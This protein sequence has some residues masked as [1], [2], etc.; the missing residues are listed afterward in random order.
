MDLLEQLRLALLGPGQSDPALQGFLRDP[1]SRPEI[2]AGLPL[3]RRSAMPGNPRGD[4]PPPDPAMRRRFRPAGPGD[5]PPPFPFAA[6]VPPGMVET[7]PAVHP[8]RAGSPAA[9]GNPVD[10]AA[11]FL[12]RRAPNTIRAPYGLLRSDVE[13]G[14]AWTQP[15]NGVVTDH[16]LAPGQEAPQRGLEPPSAPMQ[17]QPAPFSMED[18]AWQAAMARARAATTQERRRQGSRIPRPGYPL[19]AQAWSDPPNNRRR[20]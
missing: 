15:Q 5:A 3:T 9:F 6:G 4:L 7:S 12:P 14:P 11:S 13:A 1:S 2:A 10:Y 16:S 19:I 18:Q 8:P 17:P 20:R